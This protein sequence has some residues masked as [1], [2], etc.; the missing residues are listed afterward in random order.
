MKKT[1][2]W[3][4]IIVIAILLVSV[5]SWRYIS[6]NEYWE[7]TIPEEY[8]E[9]VFSIGE[10]VVFG[11]DIFLPEGYA[12]CVNSIDLQDYPERLP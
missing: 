8:S 3:I 11:E 4:L 12:L 10:T 7:S 1:T 6:L 9:T 5:W 2:K